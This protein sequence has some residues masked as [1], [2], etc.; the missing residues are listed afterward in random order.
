MPRPDL[1]RVP[2]FY[3]GYI[4][5]VKENDLISA[6]RSSTSQLFDLL[7]SIPKEKHDYR[8][9][10]GKWTVKDVVQHMLDGE[11]VFTYRALRFARKDNTPLPGFDENLFAQTAKAD[12]RNWNDIVEEF[13][14]LRKASEAMFASF[15]NEQLEQEGVA[16]KNSIYVLGIG[17]IV[18]GHVNHHCQIIR[19]RYL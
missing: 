10:E 12:K 2:E 14:A 5:K 7:K 11:R 19:E 18:A 13:A 6:L 3:H 17:F 1:S 4:N 9:A 15:D 16:S 8:Y